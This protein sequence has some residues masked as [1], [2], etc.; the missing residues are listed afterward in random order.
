MAFKD[1]FK[2]FRQQKELSQ[3]Q[4]AAAL[5]IAVRTIRNYE[6]GRSYPNVEVMNQLET[7]Y[8]VR[9]DLLMDEQDEFIAEAQAQGGTRGK[10]GAA[11]LVEQVRAMFAGGELSEEDKDAVMQE[12]QDIYW[13][14]KKEN[15][16][17]TPKKYRK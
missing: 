3:E 11:R 2:E 17:Y 9:M 16:K 13:D 12:L 5:G 6:A 14:A 1:R 10:R 4:L 15:K 7:M 8:N